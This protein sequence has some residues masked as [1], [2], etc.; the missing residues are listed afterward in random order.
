MSID[1]R[2]PEGH[3]ISVPDRMAGKT[4]RCPNCSQLTTVP[5]AEP[6]EP[7]SSGSESN[8]TR[9]S[10][11]K[12]RESKPISSMPTPL[13]PV[14]IETESYESNETE[15][16]DDIE[17]AGPIPRKRRPPKVPKKGEETAPT[18]QYVLMGATN[19]VC[20]LIGFFIGTALAPSARHLVNEVDNAQYASAADPRTSAQ[21]DASHPLAAKSRNLPSR[22]SLNLRLP[23]AERDPGSVAATASPQKNSITAVN[24]GTPPVTNQGIS[25]QTSP[26]QAQNPNPPA[27]ASLQAKRPVHAVKLDSPIHQVVVGKS[28]KLLIATL[29]ESKQVVIVDVAS[30]RIIR[31]I[32]LRNADVLIAAGESKLVVLDRTEC[33]IS[34]FDLTSLQ[35]ELTV[36]CEP[37]RSIALGNSSEGPVLAVG[38]EFAQLNLQSLKPGR[39]VSNNLA[40]NDVGNLLA[41]ANGQVFSGWK[42]V[43]SPSGMMVLRLAGETLESTHEEGDCGQIIPGADG[44][45]IYTNQGRYGADCKSLDGQPDNHTR[46]EW[47]PAAT[48]PFY[49]TLTNTGENQTTPTTLTLHTQNS[50]AT[51]ATMKNVA[52]PDFCTAE[53]S[54]QFISP[55]QFFLPAVDSFVSVVDNQLLLQRVSVKDEL[56]RPAKPYVLVVS[57]PPATV[58]RGSQFAYNIETFPKNPSTQFALEG[59][60]QGMTISKAGLIEWKVPERYRDDTVTA[61]VKVQGLAG[62]TTTQQLSLKVVESSKS[63]SES[64]RKKAM[65]ASTA[66]S[67]TKPPATPFDPKSEPALQPLPARTFET[68]ALSSP[69]TQVIVGGSGQFVIGFAP[70]DKQVVV[71]DVA[72]RKIS[73]SITVED[74][75]TGL[76]AGASKLIVLQRDI[77]SMSRYDLTTLE[78]ELTVKCDS[79]KSIVMGS[80]SDGPL[81]A[82]RRTGKS[83]ATATAIDLETLQPTGSVIPFPIKMDGTALLASANGKLFSSWSTTIDPNGMGL[84][85]FDGD[86]PKWFFDANV[87]GPSFPSV[88][89]RLVYTP[90]RKIAS[91]GEP[92]GKPIFAPRLSLPAA[93]GPWC[94]TL[95]LP[96][97]KY[98]QDPAPPRMFVQYQT[99]DDVAFAM[100]DIELPNLAVKTTAAA[101]LNE[102]Y[103]QRFFLMPDANALAIL[104]ATMD[105][106]QIYKF[107]LKEELERSGTDY[108]EVTSN[109]TISLVRGKDLSYQIEVLSKR[110][111]PHFELQNGPN[112]MSITKAGLL[113]WKVPAILPSKEVTATVLISDDSGQEVA[114]TVTFTN[115][116]PKK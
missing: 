77:G 103:D 26:L 9:P 96:E 75:D 38:A 40:A 5:A 71:I 92:I 108:L 24:N 34:R 95:T 44:Q 72:R 82:V 60:P 90:N 73:K 113:S 20:G 94:L 45:V 116:Q 114:H 84:L 74:A 43:G 11:A 78:A 58:A 15:S 86:T 30:K 56:D 65:P 61:V 14:E 70:A 79:Y 39:V 101:L 41:A 85:E 28:G 55:R 80:S 13:K 12:P 16:W 93:T 51:L 69:L 67:A 23:L 22:I 33:V 87:T 102:K 50:D 48:G 98:T 54:K 7:K 10:E 59:A 76:A 105:R 42:T 6:A 35:R 25:S 2:C 68:I 57:M 49:L 112:G 109:P 115:R 89:S 111:N 52:L 97:W 47:V 32:K 3:Q 4:I 37:Y 107:D 46:M 99:D 63:G 66:K 21:S 27:N 17:T 83:E 36:A 29:P 53:Q 8:Q 31:T 19:L 64:S 110:G 91:T 62:A 104:S 106:V 18:F 81:L 100:T 1:V 88:D